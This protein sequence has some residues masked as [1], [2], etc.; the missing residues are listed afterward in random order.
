[1]TD[2]NK[3]NDI[4]SHHNS[5][6]ANTPAP[7]LFQKVLHRAGA[8]VIL[9]SLLT[10]TGT[11]SN[12]WEDA[13]IQIKLGLLYFGVFAIGSYYYNNKEKLLEGNRCATLAICAVPVIVRGV[14][15]SQGWLMLDGV[16]AL[17]F[18]NDASSVRGVGT[19]SRNHHASSSTLWNL[20]G[21][22]V[23]MSLATMAASIAAC[24]LSPAPQPLMTVPH[25]LALSCIGIELARL[26]RHDVTPHIDDCLLWGFFVLG[27]AW[28]T[29]RLFYSG[30]TT[31]NNVDYARYFYMM[32][33]SHVWYAV[34]YKWQIHGTISGFTNAL[35][36]VAFLALYATYCQRR[37]FQVL[38]MLGLAVYVLRE[39]LHLDI[40]SFACIT[41]AL[42][43]ALVLIGDRFVFQRITA[44]VS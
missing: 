26:Y 11:A 42:G 12:K 30:A 37:I 22:L 31:T 24:R 41:V 19:T 21:Y 32:G 13:D 17:A 25:V 40:V 27:Y 20:H 7:T 14:M 39:A 9:L 3:P 2:N 16:R 15:A 36:N 34:G 18:D 8:L 5:Y 6:V 44:S 35:F 23:P 10:V 28:V 29:E 43:M 1:M 38:G 33:A 4:V